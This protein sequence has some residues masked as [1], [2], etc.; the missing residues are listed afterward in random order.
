MPGLDQGP[1][2]PP[3][4]QPQ[5]QPPA[6]SI[7]GL[8]GASGQ[9]GVGATGSMQKAL[10]EKLMFIEQAMNEV[11]DLTPSAAPLMDN[12]ISTMRTGMAKIL[13]KGAQPAPSMGPGALVSGPPVMTGP[14]GA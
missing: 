10:L 8:A 14:A 13:V 4:L 2:L 1:P 12:L 5:Q 6:P 9:A 7:A 11:A 3:D